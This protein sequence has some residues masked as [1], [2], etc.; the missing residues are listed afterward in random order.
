M[1]YVHVCMDVSACMCF[2]VHV[3]VNQQSQKTALGLN[4]IS[5]TNAPSL[6][7]TQGLSQTVFYTLEIA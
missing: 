6:R 7:K 3:C 5:F 4:K 2:H 1:L